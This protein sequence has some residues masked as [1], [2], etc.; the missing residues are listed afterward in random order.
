M[1]MYLKE[2]FTAQYHGAIQKLIIAAA[3]RLSCLSSKDMRVER[4][5]PGTGEEASAAWIFVPTALKVEVAAREHR[6]KTIQ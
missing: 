4:S 1:H 2:N 6:E 5:D 3:S